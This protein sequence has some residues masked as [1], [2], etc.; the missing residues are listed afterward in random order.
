[1]SRPLRIAMFVGSFPVVSETFILRQIT[2]LLDLGHAVDI[3][4]DT[5]AEVEAPVHPEVG[6]YRLLERT[7]FMDMPPETAPWEMPVWPLTGRTWLP[8]SETSVHN[9]VRL[10]QAFPKLLR[11]LAHSPRLTLQVLRRGQYRYQ[12][13]SL[14]ALHRLAVLCRKPKKYDVLHAHFGPVA[15]SFRF[16]RV[17]WRAPMIVSFHGYDFSSRPRKQGRDMYARLFETVDA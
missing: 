3:Y 10:G 12:A 14:S 1:M 6:R 11:C 16:A 17:L 13:A 15:D 7:T 4:A 8:G 9:S 5:R 2:G